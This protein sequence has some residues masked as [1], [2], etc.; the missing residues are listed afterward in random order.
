MVVHSVHVSWVNQVGPL[1]WTRSHKYEWGTR[2][3]SNWMRCAC[4]GLVQNR[5]ETEEEKL[6]ATEP[7]LKV[8]DDV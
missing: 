4:V 1:V 8:K 5:C 3:E 6:T 2:N 7:A